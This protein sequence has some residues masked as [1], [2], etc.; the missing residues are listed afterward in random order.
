MYP[1]RLVQDLRPVQPW[2]IYA[3]PVT[4]PGGSEPETHERRFAVKWDEDNDER[5]LGA[6]LAAFYAD[7]ESVWSLFAV[8]EH[9][10][11]LTVFG[12]EFS[13][14]RLAAWEKASNTP[15][16]LDHWPLEIV[17]TYDEIARI[18]GLNSMKLEAQ[19][20]IVGHFN[21]EYDPLNA[22]IELYELGPTGQR[23][24]WVW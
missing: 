23:R 22:L 12:Q 9:K 20:G 6:V 7:P 1:L 3:L 18:G 14:L 24:A 10:G 8:G 5:V 17:D 2:S 15:C 21:S 13:P 19:G 16:L 11:S 4:I